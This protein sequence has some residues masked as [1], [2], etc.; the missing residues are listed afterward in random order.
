MLVIPS[1]IDVRAHPIETDRLLLAPMDPEDGPELWLAVQG[2]RVFLQ[3]WLPWVQFHTDPGSS[4]RFAEACASE[5][6]QGWE[7]SGLP[8]SRT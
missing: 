6:E 7:D 3:R 4:T 1:R 2:S 8:V 5:I